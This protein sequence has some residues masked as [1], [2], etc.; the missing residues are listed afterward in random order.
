MALSCA[1]F[2]LTRFSIDQEL[3]TAV[4]VVPIRLFVK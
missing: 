4:E 3:D 1:V 2:S